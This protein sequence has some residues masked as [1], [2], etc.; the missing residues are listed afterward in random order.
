MLSKLQDLKVGTRLMAAFGTLTLLLMVG[1]GIGIFIL[2]TFDRNMDGIIHGD[3]ERNVLAN[4]VIGLANANARENTKL[5]ITDDFLAMSE[6][7]DQIEANSAQVDSLLDELEARAPDAAARALIADIRKAREPYAAVFNKVQG[8]VLMGDRDG[9]ETLMERDLLPALDELVAAIDALIEQEGARLE[10]SGARVHSGAALGIRWVTIGAIL[11]VGFSIVLTLLITRSI[12]APLSRIGWLSRELTRG[13]MSARIDA[14]A[15]DEMGEASREF[16]KL[17]WMLQEY[18]LGFLNR[19]AAGDLTFEPLD[20]DQGDEI[21]PAQIAIVESLS[22]LVREITGLTDAA[23]SGNLEARGD[24]NQ[25]DGAYRDVL[26]GINAT[27]DAVVNPVQ[28]GNAAIARLAD[29]DFTVRVTGDYHGDHAALKD[30]LNRTVEQL[31]GTVEKILAAA[32]SVAT[33]SN[34]VRDTSHNM[35]GAAEETT[36]QANAVSSAAGEASASVEVVASAAEEMAS[37]IQEITTQVHE[38]LSVASEAVARAEETGRLMDELGGASREIGEV[39]SVITGIAE[40]TNLLALNATIEAARAG[41][42]GKGFAVVANEVKQLA[43]E[44]AKATEEISQQ[45]QGVQGSS[46]RAVT[47]I[48]EVSE[49]IDRINGIS[50]SIAAAMEQQSHTVAEIAR[51]AAE[52]S[53]GTDE[54]SRSIGGVSS[55]SVSTAQG[56]EQLTGASEALAGVAGELTGLVGSFQV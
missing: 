23:V 20:S 21:G 19:V 54:V 27:L 36:M 16:D 26:A 13:H 17:A 35:A 33:S 14:L 9:A 22:G 2:R 49:V 42:A 1:C 55:A 30:N 25:F 41:E 39:V 11:I 10:A 52:A 15:K 8:S 5:L 51:R 34:Q 7:V 50:T 38:A 31:S 56:A 18:L 46:E 3:W 43:S 6:Y 40:Q 12:T 28:E 45:I 24:A 29:G 47:G 53:Q 48:A 32:E 37:S 44:T 4:R